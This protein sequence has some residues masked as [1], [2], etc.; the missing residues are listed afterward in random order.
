MRGF[1]ASTILLLALPALAGAVDPQDSAR[2]RESIEENIETIEV[3]GPRTIRLPDLTAFASI[4]EITTEVEEMKTLA[5]VLE[6]AVGVQVRRYGGLGDFSTVSIRG[7]SPSQ[8]RIYMDGIPL[9]RARSETVNLA[10]LPLDPLEAIEVFRGTTPLAFS[11]ASLGGTV[12]LLTREPGKKS[13]FS[14]LVG[15]GSFGTRKAN[16]TASG[17]FGDWGALI[18]GSYLGSEGDFPFPDNNGT[19]LNPFD[20]ETTRRK[21]NDFN[22]GDL[23]LKATYDGLSIGQLSL[24]SEFFFNE[25]GVPGIGSHQSDSVRLKDLRSLNYLRLDA[26]DLA[27]SGFDLRT[28]GYFV[29]EKEGLSDPFGEVAGSRLE[30]DNQTLSS[31][32]QFFATRRVDIHDLGARVDL[33]GETFS[34]DNKLQPDASDDRQSRLHMNLAIGDTLG[35][36]SDRL[37]LDVQLRYE[38]IRNFFAGSVPGFGPYSQ[39]SDA[40][41]FNLFTPQL[42]VDFQILPGLDARAN[43]GHYGRVPSFIEL[44]GQRGSITG[45]PSLRPEEG[46]QTDF[47][48]A[49]SLYDLAFLDQ[50]AFESAVFFSDID[51]LIVL[52]RTA[53]D[54]S[55]PQN[56]GRAKTLGAEI[57]MRATLFEKLRLTLNYTYQDARDRSGATGIDGNQLPGRPRDD[58][59]FRSSYRWR[60]WEPFYELNFIGSNYLKRANRPEDLVASRLLHSLGIAWTLPWTPLTATFEVRNL[61]D[62]QTEDV[63]GFPLPGRTFLGTVNWSWESSD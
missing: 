25:Q 14:T 56:V 47:G 4:I 31:G 60:D 52:V 1:L 38:F 22:S 27:G 20:D 59:Y 57:A 8:V 63:S 36:F 16:A 29:Y 61:S 45:N 42:G 28:T 23:L 39:P 41:T 26:P 19:P 43:I 35:F 6:D 40:D 18:T 30:T 15:G 33:S 54:R 44:F 17:S 62:N 11:A 24:L 37:L 50:L 53:Q 12:N 49:W 2:Q 5:D 13:T 51:D 46:L 21:N 9:T 34:P 48:L 3:T 55:V 7:S 10:D 32:L 58:L